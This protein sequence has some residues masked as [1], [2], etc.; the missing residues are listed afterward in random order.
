MYT[1]IRYVLLII[2]V[3]IFHPGFVFCQGADMP[4]GSSVTATHPLIIDTNAKAE[5]FAPGIVSSP[6]TEW[7]TS[8]TPDGNT[9]YFS[10]GAIYWTIV[11][12]TRKNGRWEKPVV[13]SFSGRWRDTD[14]FVTPDGNRLF[15]ISYRPLDGLPADKPVASAHI[16]YADRLSENNWGP[17]HCLDTLVNINGTGNYA[18]SV[19]GKGTLFFCSRDREGH[20]GMNS[21]YA[22]WKGD[23]YGKPQLIKFD[24]LAESQDPFIAPDE[25]YIVFLSG[26]DLYMAGRKDNGWASPEKL[27][28]A[29][30]NGDGNSSPY[31]SPDG[32]TLYYSSNRIQGFY[33]RDPQHH[34]LNYEELVKENESIFNSQGNILMIPIH[35][36]KTAG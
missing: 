25:S 6:F 21:Y 28:A 11:Y 9:V 30:N 8:F 36:S 18:P 13:A 29:V 1:F 23:R 10:R 22:E 31:V 4:K 12:S 32:K 5:A 20:S 34:A 35:L 3:S 2:L 17:P 24:G 7:A 33:K 16:W 26:N 27:C 15:F 19:S 14:P